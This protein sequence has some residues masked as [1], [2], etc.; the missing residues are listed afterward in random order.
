V[1]QAP[2]ATETGEA[3]RKRVKRKLIFAV[4]AVMKGDSLLRRGC[5]GRMQWE[6]RKAKDETERFCSFSEILLF[7][8]RH[9]ILAPLVVYNHLLFLTGTVFISKTAIGYDLFLHFGGKLNLL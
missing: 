5:L 6:G 9:K 7:I 8:S 3:I 1:Y 4:R 2:E